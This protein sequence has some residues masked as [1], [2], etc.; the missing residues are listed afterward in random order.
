MNKTYLSV[1]ISI[2]EMIIISVFSCNNFKLAITYK[3]KLSS[4]AN[5]SQCLL[6]PFIAISKNIN[7]NILI[8]NQYIVKILLY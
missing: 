6:A 5:F 3:C 4:L 1:F 8:N 2:I 7:I